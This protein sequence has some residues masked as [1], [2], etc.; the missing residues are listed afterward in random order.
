[1]QTDVGFSAYTTFHQ[2]LAA[3]ERIRFEG[4]TTKQGSHYKPADSIFTCPFTGLY[5]FIF[6]VYGILEGG[7]RIHGQIMQGNDIVAECYSGTSENLNE[8]YLQCSNSA[9]VICQANQP[10]YMITGTSNTVILAIG[11]RSS[12]S[13]FLVQANVSASLIDY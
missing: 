7:E 11:V 3:G 13:G 5:Y 9:A 1:M 8:Y 10:V 12:F 2:V 6:S 4:V